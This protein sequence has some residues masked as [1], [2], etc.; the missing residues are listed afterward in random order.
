[1]TYPI[2]KWRKR[3]R[4][5]GGRYIYIEDECVESIIVSFSSLSKSNVIM[6]KKSLN[7]QWQER[8]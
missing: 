4:E 3:E 1:M 5:A 8:T 6:E 7:E 2:I